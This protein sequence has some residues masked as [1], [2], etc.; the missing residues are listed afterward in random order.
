MKTSTKSLVGLGAVLVIVGY[1]LFGGGIQTTQPLPQPVAQVPPA[2]PRGLQ[3]LRT[4]PSQTVPGA[5]NVSHTFRV[6]T[7]TLRRQIE[8]MPSDTTAIL[9][10]AHLLDD[11]HQTE[12]A[13]QYY[14]KYLNVSRMNPQV[15]LDLTN[16]YARL[17][18]WDKAIAT[19]K[20][21]LEVFPKHPAAMYNL[22]AIFANQG[23]DDEALRWWLQ[24]QAQQEDPD[25][26]LKAQHSL[27]QLSNR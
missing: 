5:N 7:E 27:L 14:N 24:V 26:A 20:A 19:S 1:F 21:L 10:L 22:G 2:A 23:D 15:W 17:E 3:P 13:V 18:Q 25:L 16:C 6:R 9:E 8:E 12:E 11:A 4:A